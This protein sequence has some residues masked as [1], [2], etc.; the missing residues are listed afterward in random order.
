MQQINKTH[1]VRIITQD[2]EIPKIVTNE[3]IDQTLSS[4][5]G[6]RFNRWGLCHRDLSKHDLSGV[7][8]EYLAKVTFNSSTK[9]PTQDKMPKD[10]DPN[11]V[12]ERGKNPMLGIK[13]LHEQG[14]DGSGVTVAA[15]DFG[16]QSEKH[17]E[18]KG[19]NIELVNL[20]D[21]TGTHF[22]S[23]GV[24]ANLCGQN[25]GI[26]PKA[27]VVY[28]NTYQGNQDIVHGAQIQ[29]LQDILKRVIGGEKIRAVNISGPLV[30][31]HKLHDLR[32]NIE[33]YEKM[34]TELMQPLVPVLRELQ[35]LGCEVID[36]ERFGRDFTC[37]EIDTMG[38]G[39]GYKKPDWYGNKDVS[40]KV[41]FVCGGKIIPEFTSD[42]GYKYEN[43]SCFSWTIPQAVGMYTLALQQ[44][45]N[46]NWNQ[47]A[48]IAKSTSKLT[49]NGV[50]IAQ[51]A[52]IIEKVK[53]QLGDARDK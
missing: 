5:R 22:H 19:S 29:I 49:E 3:W 52:A 21:D 35:E 34:K 15:I 37:C 8:K 7:S 17:P 27:N 1:W 28:Y 16:F 44:N 42:S 41:S 30:R 23:D 20:F 51:P 26:A 4:D 32:K 9:W 25:V 11:I 24:L 48:E 43:S 31:N 40:D 6:D 39:N 33:E 53:P 50:R 38:G 47:F 45:P 10:F 13:K 18:Y 14:I 2:F 12:L 46:L 36:S